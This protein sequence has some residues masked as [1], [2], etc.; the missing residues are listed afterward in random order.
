MNKQNHSYHLETL[1]NINILDNF[2]DINIDDFN[3]S[4]FNPYF[5]ILKSNKSISIDDMNN[6]IKMRGGQLNNLN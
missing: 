5:G 2:D 4:Q 3:E 6:A 1:P